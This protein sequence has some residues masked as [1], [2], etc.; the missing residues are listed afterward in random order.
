MPYIEVPVEPASLTMHQLSSHASCRMILLTACSSSGLIFKYTTLAFL[1]VGT[2]KQHTG[3]RLLRGIVRICKSEC[4]EEDK[5]SLKDSLEFTQAKVASL[6]SQVK[7]ATEE[8]VA[9]N[10]KIVKI[11]T[12]EQRIIKQECFNRRNNIKFFGIKDADDES[13]RDTETKL[14]KFLKKEMQITNDELEDIQFERVHRIPTRPKPGKKSQPR[15]IIA[16]IS[17]FQD[18]EFIKSHIK[19]LPKGVKYGVADDFP[20][21]VDEIRKAL[22]PVL[23][24]ARQEK[25]MAFFNVEKLIVEGA[26]YHGPETK[27]FPLYGR[28]MESG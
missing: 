18:K 13:P 24:K 7:S 25:K 10:K 11:N 1:L 21:E 14:R 4:L 3:E 27:K 19:D 2:Y 5:Q 16:K 15:A 8:V 28:I 22:Y 12:L 17:F 23:K 20:K 9:A 6:K 26:V